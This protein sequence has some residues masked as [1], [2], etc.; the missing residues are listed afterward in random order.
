MRFENKMIRISFWIILL[1]NLCW[2]VDGFC[3][4]KDYQFVTNGLAVVAMLMDWFDYD[5]LR[6]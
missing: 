1:A 4:G 6:K 3:N 5:G 2:A